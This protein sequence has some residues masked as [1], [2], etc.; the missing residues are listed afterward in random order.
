LNACLIFILIAGIGADDKPKEDA[1]RFQGTWIVDRVERNGKKE[2]QLFTIKVIF[3]GEKILSKVGKRD[4]D[5]QGTFKLDPKAKPK[6]YVVTTSDGRVAKGIYELK[7]DTLKVCL[8]GPD[9]EAPTTFE[10]K[11]DDNR[12]LIVYRREKPAK[13]R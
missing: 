12:T 7:D 13:G 3:D 4:P 1:D 2:S 10:T 6:G 5:P 8:S 9:D 11:E